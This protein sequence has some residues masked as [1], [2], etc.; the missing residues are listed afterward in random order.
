MASRPTASPC[1]SCTQADEGQ[2]LGYCSC[3]PADA[4]QRETLSS[5][6][7]DRSYRVASCSDQARKLFVGDLQTLAND[8][9]LHAVGEVK[10]VACAGDV[11]SLHCHLLFPYR[12]IRPSIACHNGGLLT[13]ACPCR[14]T[15]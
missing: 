1:D 11:A 3:R 14:C 15:H 5:F 10:P 7:I 6:P 4:G 12:P 2:R 9:D 8:P 13:A